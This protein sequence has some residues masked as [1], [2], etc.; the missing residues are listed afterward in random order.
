V[1][2]SSCPLFAARNEG[3]KGGNEIKRRDCDAWFLIDF[4]DA[5][6]SPQHFPNGQHLSNEEHAPEI[7][8][9]CGIHTTAVDSR[10]SVECLAVDVNDSGYNGIAT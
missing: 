2:Q 1:F 7:F 5:V 8:V 6:I 9:S 3:A 4:A 10:S